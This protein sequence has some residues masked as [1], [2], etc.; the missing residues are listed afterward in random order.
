M[1]DRN[2][3]ILAT[4]IE[5]WH[6][7]QVVGKL[8]FDPQVPILYKLIPVAALIYLISPIDVIPDV[9]LGPGQLDDAAVVLF[10]LSLFLRLVPQERVDMARSTLGN[11]ER[12]ADVEV[13][14]EREE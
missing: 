9:L 2:Q 3:S 11:R 10:A 1:N 13:K 5:K 7:L 6:D 8:F 14:V 4:L 12:D